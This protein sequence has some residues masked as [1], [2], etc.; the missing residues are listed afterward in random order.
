MET[1]IEPI[2]NSGGEL[3]KAS[4]IAQPNMSKLTKELL[5]KEKKLNELYK[6]FYKYN[7]L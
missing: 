1:F 3:Y 4:C 6:A 2:M 5:T 7:K